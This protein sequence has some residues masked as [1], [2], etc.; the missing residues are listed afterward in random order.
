MGDLALPRA[1]IGTYETVHHDSPQLL[2]HRVSRPARRCCELRE[3]VLN[4]QSY[5]AG[6]SEP[7][8]YFDF[9]DVSKVSSAIATADNDD[10]DGLRFYHHSSNVKVR[11]SELTQRME[12]LH[13]GEFRT[14]LMG[15]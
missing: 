1:S 8:G 4:P 12:V 6:P 14:F 2:Y 5:G 10:R 11:L 13:G 3:P 15:K 9:E 7:Y